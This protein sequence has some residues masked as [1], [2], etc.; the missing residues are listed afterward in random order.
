MA[1]DEYRWIQIRT[2]KEWP[3]MNGMNADRNRNELAAKRTSKWVRFC[4]FGVKRGH[5][6]VRRARQGN[7]GN[8]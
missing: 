6:D 1:T 3:Q 5:A 4:G 8:G 7:I 2:K